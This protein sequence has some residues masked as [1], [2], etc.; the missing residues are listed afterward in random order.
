MKKKNLK[1]SVPTPTAEETPKTVTLE[2]E[3]TL[4]NI[5]EIQMKLG[6]EILDHNNLTIELKNIDNIDVS[7][8]QLLNAIQR[9]NPNIAIKME[10]PSNIEVLLE[11][12]GF[13]GLLN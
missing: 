2:G 3:L 6:F 7:F 12:G 10:F 4:N 8:L 11:R 1:I 13:A 9:Y 5:Q